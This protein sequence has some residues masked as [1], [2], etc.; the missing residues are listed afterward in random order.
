MSNKNFQ[1]DI[2]QLEGS[3][4]DSH[5]KRKAFV[6]WNIRDEN[7]RK[8]PLTVTVPVFFC[9]E[10]KRERESGRENGTDI[11]GYRGRNISVGNI[12]IT[13]GNR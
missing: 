3:N 11:T 7:G 4:D 5:A 6:G 13:I 10:R 12:S 8:N 1:K 2:P 9:R